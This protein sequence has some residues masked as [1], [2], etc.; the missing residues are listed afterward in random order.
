MQIRKKIFQIVLVLGWLIWSNFAFDNWVP[1]VM[2]GL[3]IFLDRFQYK[4][5]Y[6]VGYCERHGID[7]KNYDGKS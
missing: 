3:I 2:T 1:Y 5:G 6:S 4:V 7:P